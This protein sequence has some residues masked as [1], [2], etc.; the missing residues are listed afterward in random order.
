MS[1]R[2]ASHSIQP[3]KIM[4]TGGGTAGHISP[5]LA[6][7]QT[8]REMDEECE[9]L[10]VG[11]KSK[12]EKSQ[13]EAANLR[14]V[15]I[16]T[17]KLRRYFSI[18]N[19]I[20]QFRIPL[21]FFQALGHIRRFKPDV[22][23]ATGGYVAV[24]PVLAA[25]VLGIP[26]LIHEQT[27]QIGLA[28]R[29]N[30][31]FA[32]KIA[33]SWESALPSLSPK[34]RE[35]AFVVGNPVRPAIFGGRASRALAHFGL[36]DGLP[37][38]YVTGGSQGARILNRA[39][40]ACLPELL[41]KCVVIHQCGEQSEGESDFDVLTRARLQLPAEKQNRYAVARF[42]KDELKDVFALADL[43]VG[44]AGAGTLAEL[45]ALGKPALYVPLVP[46]GGDEQSKNAQMCVQQGAAQIL[47]QKECDGENLLKNV[48]KLL[49]DK[50]NLKKMG[51]SAK[52]LAKPAAARDLAKVVLGMG[53]E[54]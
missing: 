40:E 32:T 5:A 8:L 35:K 45:C 15:A 50:T 14:F 51:E 43:V 29:I 6:V 18:E 39:V 10:Y 22:V 3:L 30:A 27:T 48:E 28:N 44:R 2:V 37:V 47:L 11:S 46:T 21:G 20:D 34:L 31:R 36:S 49:G 52:T 7:V 38:V 17:G 33:L 41:E 24:A 1:E 19:A 13:I 23:L 12:L 54:R 4:L 9:F 26:I 53:H 25:R 42:I 16:A